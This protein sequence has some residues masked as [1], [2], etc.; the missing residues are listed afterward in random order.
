MTPKFDNLVNELLEE[1]AKKTKCTHETLPQLSD[2]KGYR[3]MRCVENPY[4]SG[5]RR[6][7]F[8]RKDGS[9][10]YDRCKKPQ[11]RGTEGFETCNMLHKARRKR[12]LMRLKRKMGGQ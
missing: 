8:G 1:A 11:R 3:F 4:S 12:A 5:I 7:Y 2:K 6:V 9:F 10:N